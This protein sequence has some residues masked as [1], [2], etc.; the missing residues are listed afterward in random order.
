M[1]ILLK[2]HLN[3]LAPA[4]G[5]IPLCFEVNYDQ[6]EEENFNEEWAWVFNALRMGVVTTVGYISN[7]Y[8]E[9]FEGSVGK[10]IVMFAMDKN[11]AETIAFFIERMDLDVV[12]TTRHG[13]HLA[14]GIKTEFFGIS[15]FTNALVSSLKTPVNLSKESF[16]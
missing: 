2:N 7:V 11:E 15:R 8:E 4:M 12:N 13:T 1:S 16:L 9:G 14:K 5:M 10:T 6:G 3:T